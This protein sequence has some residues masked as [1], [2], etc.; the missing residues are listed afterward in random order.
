MCMQSLAEGLTTMDSPSQASVAAANSRLVYS[1]RFHV[2]FFHHQ[3][4]AFL[5]IVELQIGRAPVEDELLV[6]LL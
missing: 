1:S 4:A 3:D 6:G 5:D 2:V